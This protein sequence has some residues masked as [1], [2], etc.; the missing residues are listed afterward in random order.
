MSIFKIVIPGRFPSLNEYINACRSRPQAGAKMKVD[1]EL[2]ISEVLKSHLTRPL[3]FPIE[4]DY[5]FFEPSKRR[6][7]DNIASF[8]HKVFMDS[9]VTSGLLPDDGWDYVDGW[10]DYFGIDKED[11]RVEV[12]IYEAGESF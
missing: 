7:K 5:E 11:P 1:S 4:L 2:R 6:D 8:F 10:K 12:T 3:T 9:L